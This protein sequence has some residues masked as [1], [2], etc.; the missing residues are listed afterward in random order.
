MR[1]TVTLACVALSLGLATA[2]TRLKS[3][4]ADYDPAQKGECV[5]IGRVDLVMDE[6]KPPKNH[7]K[8]SNT[9][10]NPT[11]TVK[12]MTTGDK[13]YIDLDGPRWE[14]YVA[15][16]PGSYSVTEFT[17]GNMRSEPPADFQI[18]A[19]APPAATEPEGASCP[20]RYV[21]SLKYIRQTGAKSFWK[22]AMTSSLPGDWR[23]EDESEQTMKGFNEA[24][25]RWTCAPQKSMMNLKT[26]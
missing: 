5:V 17:S 26:E 23:V 1:I 12:N 16:P 7:G 3:I 9:M 21:G 14:F 4:P 8:A 25:A 20:L 18:Q 22:G 24:Y 2:A 19:C 10:G 15:L 6:R 13:Y 11:L